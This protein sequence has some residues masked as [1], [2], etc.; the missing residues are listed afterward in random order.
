MAARV[1]GVMCN[2]AYGN[3]TNQDAIR[4]AGAVPLLVARLDWTGADRRETTNAAGALHNLAYRNVR[5]PAR[6][7]AK[8]RP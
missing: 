5:H 4:E 1:A 7:R 3:K 8:T 2:L 6:C